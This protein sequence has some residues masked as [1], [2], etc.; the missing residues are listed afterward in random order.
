MIQKYI[1]I[2]L[3]GD[4]STG[5]TPEQ[6]AYLTSTFA[7][8]IAGAGL[9]PLVADQPAHILSRKR[10]LNSKK[11]ICE[12]AWTTEPTKADIIAA[13]VGGLGAN[14]A[15]LVGVTLAEFPA[16]LDA[17]I[18]MTVFAPEGDWQASGDACRAY[19]AA[20]ISDWEAP[21]L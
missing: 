20:N 16:F 4:L 8:A 2:E 6:D 10:S 11:L 5:L 19:L 9:A 12:A 18:A 13:L 15:A 7:P 3:V 14:G 1:L 21:D 17:N